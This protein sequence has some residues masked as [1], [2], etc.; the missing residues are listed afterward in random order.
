MFSKTKKS[1][2]KQVLCLF[3]FSLLFASLNVGTV[4]AN[5]VIYIRTDGNIEGT[6]KIQREGIVYTF[7]ENIVNQ[8]LVVERDNIVIDGAGYILEGDEII[9]AIWLENRHNV[10]I[11]NL[12]ITNFGE[13]IRVMG[14]C[15][16]NAIIGNT[17][18]NNGHI[19]TTGNAIW[20]TFGAT[21]T[22]ILGNNITGNRVGIYVYMSGG[23]IISENCIATNGMGI[24]LS[25]SQNRIIR[26]DIAECLRF[27]V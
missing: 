22:T 9:S 4:K 13:G 24:W 19:S 10:T 2:F 27:Y 8:K 7:T 21:N 25:A 1:V 12:Q 17:I 11:M 16:N 15:E 14:N 5:D 23:T 20:V 18:T 3:A 6:D 26:N